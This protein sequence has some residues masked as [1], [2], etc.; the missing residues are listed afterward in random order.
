MRKWSGSKP[1]ASLTVWNAELQ[2]CGRA[3][4]EFPAPSAQ[5]PCSAVP[6]LH[7][8]KREREHA[9]AVQLAFRTDGSTVRE[10]DM[11]CDGQP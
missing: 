7:S 11:L 3:F 8:R 2:S 10:H 4:S 5:H 6:I 1:D 9:P